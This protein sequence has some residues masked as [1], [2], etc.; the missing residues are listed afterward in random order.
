MTFSNVDASLSLKTKLCE[1]HYKLTFAVAG[2]DGWLSYSVDQGHRRQ[3]C[4]PPPWRR[5]QH[6]HATTPQRSNTHTNTQNHCSVPHGL[7]TVATQERELSHRHRHIQPD[8]MAW[9]GIR[10]LL[11][12]HH[13]DTTADSM[14]CNHS[15]D[16]VS[17]VSHEIDIEG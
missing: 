1:C 15:H 17:Q 3:P 2:G 8:N 4:I 14:P 9:H 5:H 6:R 11:S 16:P 12:F 7:I 10:D 13:G